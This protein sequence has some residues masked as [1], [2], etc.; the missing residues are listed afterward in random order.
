M[1]K[2]HSKA[3]SAT[4]ST[5]SFSATS[6]GN[7]G[8]SGGS[9]GGA[10]GF[11][12]SHGPR[13]G[14]FL[15]G[16]TYLDTIMHVNSFPSE[17]TKQRAERVEQRRGG[18]AANTAEVLGQDPKAKVW[19]MSSMPSPVASK[20]LLKALEDSNVKTDACVYHTSQHAPPQAYIISANNSQTR[21]IIS[22]STLPDL[23]L[24]DFIK[25]F[26]MACMKAVSDIVEISCP[27]RWIHFEGRGPEVYKM[28]EYVES[29]Y[30]RQG[31][32]HKLTIS[33]EFEKGDRPGIKNLL[34]QADV[35]FFSKLYAETLGFDR[36]EDFLSSIGDYCK[37]TA[38]LF[39]CWGAQGAVGLHLESRTRFSSSA[40]KVDM[41]V[42]P[43]GAGD[44][45]I[46]GIILALGVRGYDIGRGVRFACELASHKC[47]QYGFKR[48]LRSLSMDMSRT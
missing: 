26:D 17:D 24:E 37:P 48:V 11:G 36:P 15:A 47:G 20:V 28:I 7:S 38:T 3:S 9:G 41:V 12:V 21:T 10:N 46:A 19:Y 23:T 5:T 1:F 13:I 22:H 33:V 39:C 43:V 35:C 29:F 8:H 44:T 14:I 30:L 32:R 2:L 27:F 18:N 31:W 4:S 25:K 45:F 34:Q 40:G 16:A 42:D 6:S